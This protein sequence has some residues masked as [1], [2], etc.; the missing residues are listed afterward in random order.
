MALIERYSAPKQLL[1][2]LIVLLASV[3]ILTPLGILIAIPFVDGDIFVKLQQMN[4]AASEQNI[5]LLKYFQIVSQLSLF[6]LSSFIFAYLV[7]KK[8]WSYLG[9]DKVP[10]LKLIVIAVVIGLVSS[11]FLDWV[12]H[13]NSNIH[14]PAFLASLE[15]WMRQMEAEATEL[16]NLFLSGDGAGSLLVNLLM[17][18][19]LAGLGEELLLRG[20]VQPLFIRITRNAHLGIWIAAALFSFMHLQ[21]LGFFPRLLLGA[22]FG[23]YYYWSRNLWIP[24]AAHIINNGIIVVYSFFYGTVDSGLQIGDLN[25]EE[26]P[27]VLLIVLSLS[28]SI[29]GLMFFYRE[30]PK[31]Q[32]E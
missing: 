23:Y 13:V 29:A 5:A 31:F 25:S 11:P 28:L 1:I 20:I 18:A 8:P 7:S 22:L 32:R 6:I 21:F 15:N 12:M 26:S 16:T 2:L 14:L 24:I 9:L 19:L 17:M 4:S 30:R 3:F 10:G 27:S